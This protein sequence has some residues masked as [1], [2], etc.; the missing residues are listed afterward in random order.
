VSLRL[1][2]VI[3]MY[4]P[5]PAFAVLVFCRRGQPTARRCARWWLREVARCSPTCAAGT[6]TEL[7]VVVVMM[8]GQ[9]LF[10]VTY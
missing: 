10:W 2:P 4:V 9:Q 8:I 1:A 5:A 3:Y 7:W 6:H